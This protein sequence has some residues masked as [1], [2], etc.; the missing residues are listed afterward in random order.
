VELILALQKESQIRV[1]C[2]DH[3]SHTTDLHPL[4]FQNEQDARI[5]FDDPAA[6]GKKLYAA[7]FPSNTI[8]QQALADMPERL[9][10]VAPEPQLDA[11]PWEYVYGSFGTGD[12]TSP[13]YT[14]NFLV[15]ECP[16]VRGLP[17]SQRISLPPI[18]QSLHIVAVPSNPLSDTIE[19]LAIDAEWTR[20]KESI[21]QVPAAIVLERT[22]PPTLERVRH[23]VANQKGR[24]VHFMGHGG[25]DQ[26]QGALL[27]FEQDNGAPHLVTAK[28]FVQRLR[29]TIFLVT[30]NACVSATP[31]PT[32]FHNL[33]AA[34]VRQKT[35]Y[36][37]GMRLSIVDEDART[38]SRVFYNE[39][40]RGVSVEEALFQTRLT[41]AKS[42]RVWV[43]GVPVLY[44]S[45][46][47]PAPGFVS[48]DGTPTV[49]DRS[50]HVDMSALPSVEGPFQGRINAMLALGTVLT[51]DQRPRILTI[52]G[53]G[54]QGKTALALKLVERFAFAWSGGVWATTLENLPIRSTFVIA[55]AQFLG[56]ETQKTLDPADIERQVLAQLNERRTLLVLDNAET[57]IDAV[58]AQN[59]DALEL[60]LFLKKLLGILACLLVTSR[61][62]LGWDDEQTYELGGLSPAE[63]AAL[64]RQG[65][66]QRRG[67]I[68]LSIAASLS[69]QLEGHPLGLRLLAGAFNEISLSLPAF[70][71]TTEERLRE[72]ENKYVGPEHRHRK[73]YACIETSVRS[74]TPA[75]R[76]LLSGL[77][78]FHAPFLADT[79]VAI[80]DSDA[81]ETELQASPIRDQLYQLQRRSL[82]TRKTVTARDGILQLYMLLPTTRP[83]VEHYLEQAYD[84]EALR[85][86]FITVYLQIARHTYDEVDRSTVLAQQVREDLEWVSNVL[87]DGAFGVEERSRYLFSW[88]WVVSRLGDSLR[89]LH[90][91]EQAKE[92]IEGIDSALTFQISL[93]MA[94][95]YRFIGRSQEALLLYEQVLPI[96]REGSDR[97]GEA[98]VLNNMALVYRDT[99]R[100]EEALLLYEEAL[101]ITRGLG[102]R[103]G[104]AATLNNIALVYRDT[105]RPEK[106]LPLYEEA[107]L[108]TRGLGHR[109]GEAATLNNMAMAYSAIG[110]SP[111]A[112]KLY[113]E[114]L[115]IIREVNYPAGE[116]TMLNN[117]AMIYRVTGYLQLAL[118]LYEEAL[119][120]MRKVENR[121]GEAAT[122]NNI[123]LVYR[124]MERFQE[125]LLLY[126]EA[127]PITREINDLAGEATALNGLAYLYQS[128]QRHGDAATA[129]EQSIV[130]S[131]QITYPAIEIASLVG[132]ASLF[133]YHLN[134]P[135]EA[136]TLLEKAIH[137]FTIT[138]LPQDAAGQTI[139][140]TQQFL[141]LIRN[142]SFSVA[143]SHA[144]EEPLP[145]HAELVPKSI[146]ALHGGPQEKMEHVHYLA[147]LAAETTDKQLKALINVI[148]LALFGSDRSQLGLDLEG[149][150]RQTW[151]TIL[152]GIASTGD[153][154]V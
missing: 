132:L 91:L 14:E 124:H 8:A 123:A 147:T 120:I 103:L 121:L 60:V 75:L 148:Q 4:L 83:Y 17:T 108:I 137:I 32:S 133:H 28:E 154:T 99:G 85:K 30:L 70:L 86:Q 113:E 149:V 69:R 10:L 49:K 118:Q 144:K 119:P 112:L 11:I 40:A 67:E 24:V 73:L 37:L 38:F 46:T 115:P 82:L 130:L 111:R 56:I 62:P 105:G 6:Y 44:T 72:A 21:Q 43:V 98:T 95:I 104:E 136:I 117:M 142:E 138:R 96:T 58:E 35:P 68:D 107:L 20:L 116:A 78:I 55:L 129:F 140:Q 33:A 145:F 89:G 16:F 12:P 23:L 122:L 39:L 22:I 77:W 59:A 128:L 50:F 51:G 53:S 125:A 64:F 151:D 41:L 15:L 61:V 42:R 31:G 3:Y 131:R 139:E 94:T 54:G 106:A 29:G 71:Q 134:R 34:L 9:L 52:L 152:A 90:L 36:A 110:N 101:P 26:Q 25:Q 57:L 66:P 141:M 88:G 84:R 109:A 100:L 146:K 76:S 135:A 153:E 80:F 114:A 13:E 81:Q 79:T 45:L 1:T 102:Y 150:Y 7:L 48:R 5:I 92:M 27:C 19:P 63:G 65:A 126:E 47:E 127:L 74:L 143:S 97:E 2:D 93:R 87:E 18:D